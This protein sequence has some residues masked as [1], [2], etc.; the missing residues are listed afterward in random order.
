[1]FMITGSETPKASPSWVWAMVIAFV[2]FAAFYFTL[3]W[4]PGQ[5]LPTGQAEE[6]KVSAEV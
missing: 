2:G 6:R 3:Y 5:L 4:S 1:M